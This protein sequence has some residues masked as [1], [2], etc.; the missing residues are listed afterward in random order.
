MP[1]PDINYASRPLNPERMEALLRYAG[2][3]ILDVGCGSGVYVLALKGRFDI[4][5]MDH[6]RYEEWQK[7][8]ELF[9]IATGEKLPFTDNSF[10]TVVSFETLEHLKEPLLALKE[11]HR[12]CRKNVILSV[13]NCDV[14]KGMLKSNLVFSHWL[15][16]THVHYFD[17][18]SIASLMTQAGFSIFRNEAINRISLA[19]LVA[20]KMG[21]APEGIVARAL[22]KT[23]TFS[24]F[25][26]YYLTRLVVAEKYGV[27]SA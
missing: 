18:N 14:T 8:P 16:R 10:D 11:Y 2:R 6:H 27:L 9:Q 20:E 22:R 17:K 25:R 15:D 5:G 13:P 1:I 7:A 4:Y 23:S 3:S 21:M 19:P 26:R 24:P 12:V